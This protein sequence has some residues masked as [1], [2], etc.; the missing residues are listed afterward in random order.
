M[1]HTD[2]LPDY[3]HKLLAVAWTLTRVE[4]IEA[5]RGLFYEENTRFDGVF[6]KLHAL[7]LVDYEKVLM[8]DI[9]LALTF[10]PD[11]LFDLPA[12]AAMGRSIAGACHGTK[13]N[14]RGIFAGE[15]VE[16]GHLAWGPAWR[17]KCWCDA[18][19]TE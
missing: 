18:L 19:G 4:Y 2:E 1:L 13:L 15:N 9:D 10:C 17:H 6:T 5:A 12:P 11:E 3:A 14:H 7:S 16:P 8:L